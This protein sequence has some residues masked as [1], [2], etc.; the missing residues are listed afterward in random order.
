MY[1]D[2]L[3]RPNAEATISY[4]RDTWHP[5]MSG[6]TL[7][8]ISDCP[9]K[10]WSK[11]TAVETIISEMAAEGWECE[12][13]TDG[14]GF[15]RINCIHT[16][17]QNAIDERIKAQN[18]KFANAE[19]G[20]IRFGRLPKSGKSRNFRD[21]TEELGISCFEADIAA[22]GSYRLHLTPAL[23][24]TWLNVMDRDVYR[25]YG[26]VIGTGADGEPVLKVS[27]ATKIA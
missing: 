21:G 1:K 10:K 4:R 17:T 27:K 23:E 13:E 18:D 16:E 20:Y 12:V 8:S 3:G 2:C 11:D 15:P 25:L 22:D 6:Y 7:H 5:E 19:I 26:E 14:F 9:E 24:I